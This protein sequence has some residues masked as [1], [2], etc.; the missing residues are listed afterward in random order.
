MP[1]LNWIR[2][3]LLL[4]AAVLFAGFALDT[5]TNFHSLT[6]LEHQ[7]MYVLALSVAVTVMSF[8]MKPRPGKYI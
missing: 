8:F 4:V 6:F 2:L 5:Y 7:D 3:V 1:V